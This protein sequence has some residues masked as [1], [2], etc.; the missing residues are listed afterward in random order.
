[1]TQLILSLGQDLSIVS[2]LFEK[3]A[4]AIK[5]LSHKKTINSHHSMQ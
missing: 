3:E 1:M 5:K 4:L 2:S